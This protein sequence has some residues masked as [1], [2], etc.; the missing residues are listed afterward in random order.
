MVG[1]NKDAMCKEFSVGDLNWIS[2]DKDI[3]IQSLDVKVRIRHGGELIL[4]RVL[5]V[6]PLEGLNP[7]LVEMEK[8]IRG[9]ASGQSAVFYTN[10]G[11]CLGGGVI[12]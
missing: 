2:G 10:D 4:A 8:G 11:V 9:V 1:E 7:Y 5:G 6:Q 3:N 12:E